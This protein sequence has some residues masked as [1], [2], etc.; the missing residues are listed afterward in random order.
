LAKSTRQGADKQAASARATPRRVIFEEIEARLLF[1]A[2]VAPGLLDGIAEVR[3][4]DTETPP[5]AIVEPAGNSPQQTTQ[6][7]A[8]QQALQAQTTQQQ[9]R[10]LVFIDTSVDQWQDLLAGIRKTHPDVEVITLDSQHDGITQISDAL[11]GRNDVSAIH[12]ITHGTAGD[13]QI[14]DSSLNAATIATYANDIENWKNALASN[15]DILLYGCDFASN[16]VGK[17]LTGVISDLT[18]ANVAAS[19]DVTGSAALG[20]NWTL[21]YDVGNVHTGVIVDTATQAS[22]QHDL[23]ITQDSVSSA[24]TSTVGSNTL[25]FSH[26]VGSGSNTILIVE[27]ADRNASAVSSVTYG[28]VALTQLASEQGVASTTQVDIWYLKSPTAGTANVVVTLGASHEFVAG[29]TSFFG[30][31]LTTPFGTPVVAQ[32]STGSPSATISSATGEVIL[33][34]VSSKGIASSTVGTGQMQLWNLENGSTSSDAWGASSTKA[35]AAS[36]TMDWT[37][38]S[39]SW[40]QIAV[41]IKPAAAV[42]TA[43]VF[44]SV[45]DFTPI[46]KN[47][48]NTAGQS[49]S[50]IFTSSDADT[51]ALSGI[52]VYSTTSG[53]GHWQYS[54][55]GGS[56]WTDTGGTVTTTSALLLRSTDLLRFVPDGLNSDYATIRAYM[57]DQTS[58]S[59]GNKVDVTTRGGT[60]AFSTAHGDANITVNDAPAFV[61]AS[62]FT[63]ITEDQTTNGG[64]LVSTLFSSTDV[65]ANAVNG[66]AV[67]GQTP[68]NGTWQYSTDGGTTWTGVGT[69]S[70]SSALLLR[71]TDYLR[72]VP[73]AHNADSASINFYIWD[74]TSGSTGT[75]VDVSTRGT[76]TAF[77]TTGGT[78]SIT[79]TAVNDAPVFVSA[80][81]FTTITEDQTKNSGQLVSTLFSNTDVDTGAVNGIALYSATPSNG[82]WQYSTDGGSTWTAVGTVSGSS[83]LLLRSTDYLRFVP[84][85]HNA[86]SA[87]INFY[88]WDQT[89]GSTGAKVDVSTR[90][91]TTAFSSTGG[92]SSI[93]VT[94][95]NDAPVLAGTNNFTAINED[96]TTSGGTLVSA[97]LSEQVSDVDIGAVTG[98][99]VTAVDNTNGIWQYTTDGGTTWTAFG[100]P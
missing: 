69:V 56:T 52:A 17:Q 32:G 18:G 9:S 90:G 12:L 24:A 82:T 65:D 74:Q 45:N 75:K 76:T 93:T 22:W 91:T 66:I 19:E 55:D 15:A 38:T 36:V 41:A 35:G 1:S 50:S 94:A 47:Q 28:G 21:E 33:D 6:Q 46:T 51:G 70:G 89:S 48:Q 60:T 78:S 23:S 72:F 95:V 99:A 13:L 81:N 8:P 88:I 39:S 49:V 43:P 42:N 29:A 20:A 37:T 92:T 57:W 40:A 68:S 25:T 67:Y 80:S 97:L 59:V 83:A 62:N 31:D 53:N 86:D 2:D 16:D 34:A 73:D 26:T 30:V 71:S 54:L 79:V 58:G 63:T 61:S 64:Q 14:G 77:S 3:Y 85:A 7:Q 4:I 10:Q 5:A 96:N 11:A 100:T 87:S 84:D 98:I 44:V 27:I